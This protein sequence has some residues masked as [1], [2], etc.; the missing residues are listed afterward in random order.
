MK[1]SM[2]ATAALLPAVAGLALA[3]QDAGEQQPIQPPAVDQAHDNTPPDHMAQQ[4]HRTAYLGVEVR[5]LGH[6]TAK[7]L[8]LDRGTGL[9]LMAVAPGSAADKAG[10]EAGD[11]LVKLDDQLL[12][13]PP[14]LAVLVQTHQPG[15]AL[16]LHVMR[17]GE[18]VS[19]DATLG[20]RPVTPRQADVP[21]GDLPRLLDEPL[22]LP[23]PRQEMWGPGDAQQI[24]ELFEQ[25][26]QRMAQQRV[27]MHQ[28]MDQMRR[29]MRLDRDVFD[30]MPPI[31]ED[32][33]GVRSV[34]SVNDGEHA[35]Q[36]RTEA[37]GRHLTVKTADGQ[38]VYEGPLPDDGKVDALPAEVQ[39]KVDNLIKGKRIKLR[40]QPGPGARP[41]EPAGP[42]A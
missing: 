11:V 37:D 39:D 10:L 35:I 7:S 42:V 2:I 29:Q 16:T 18:V 1:L 26:R 38:V 41:A 17:D 20:E 24:D 22:P 15:D 33:Q 3:R 31:G 34:V 5:P 25:M 14:Q 30:A 23:E 36:I 40:I 28:M 27:E 21:P 19:L 13:N 32:L 9:R 12:I 8:G 6:S 4:A